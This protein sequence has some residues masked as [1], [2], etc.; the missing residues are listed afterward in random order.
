MTKSFVDYSSEIS[1]NKVGK[2]PH[3]RDDK[4]ISK[5]REYFFMAFN[6][7]IES[8]R[9]NDILFLD[10]NET[11]PQQSGFDLWFD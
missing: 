1:M 4:S 6:S 3:S 8:K 5:F 9:K 10:R 7:L 11:S 2:R